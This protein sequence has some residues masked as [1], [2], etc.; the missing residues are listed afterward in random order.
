MLIPGLVDE[1]GGGQLPAALADVRL[2]GDAA[3]RVRRA[4]RRHKPELGILL[5]RIE[6]S[7][8]ELVTLTELTDVTMTPPEA[9]DP[10]RFAPPPGSNRSEDP[11]A[12]LPKWSTGPVETKTSVSAI[13]I[14]AV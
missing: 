1:L 9:A 5:R 2:G 14:A 8:G 6:T 12:G 10:A 3:A 4:R 7:G 11:A 13:T